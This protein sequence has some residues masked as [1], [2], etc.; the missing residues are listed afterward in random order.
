LGYWSRDAVW[1]RVE[2]A[3]RGLP[4]P[5]LFAVSS[6]LRVSEAVLDESEHAALYVYKGSM[7]PSQVQ[8]RIA[9]LAKR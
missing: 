6:R 1:R 7:S 8:K 9:L 4:A 3:Q 2:M 5:V